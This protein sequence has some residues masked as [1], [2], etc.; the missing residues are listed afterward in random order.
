MNLF[1]SKGDASEYGSPFSTYLNS[2]YEVILSFGI[3]VASFKLV[4]KVSPV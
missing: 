4:H 1:S 2:P 3:Y